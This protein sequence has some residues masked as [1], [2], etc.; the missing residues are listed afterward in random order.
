MIF[1]YHVPTIYV[2]RKEYIE[3]KLG[4]KF[5]NEVPTIC[6][7]WIIVLQKQAEWYSTIMYPQCVCIEKKI[8]ERN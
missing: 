2:Y 7:L 8:F 6:V 5:N 3:K 1:N 4:M